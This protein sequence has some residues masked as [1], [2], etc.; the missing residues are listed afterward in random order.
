MQDLIGE[1]YQFCAAFFV[2]RRHAHKCLVGERDKEEV[3]DAA[4]GLND[5]VVVGHQIGQVRVRRL[6]DAWMT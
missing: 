3:I 4:A 5:Q 2:A 6:H 1:R